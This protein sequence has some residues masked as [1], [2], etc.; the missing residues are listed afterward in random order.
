MILRLRALTSVPNLLIDYIEI[1]TATGEKVRLTWDES[2]ISYTPVGFFARY[3]GVYIGEEYANGRID[4]LRDMVIT[5]IGL[6]DLIITDAG[7]EGEA[8]IE[9]SISIS[10]MEFCDD[11]RSLV[12]APP[13]DERR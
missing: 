4:E 2:G 11:R 13:I 12:F 8:G 1:R 3:K 5:G 6:E 7:M 9:P 10:R